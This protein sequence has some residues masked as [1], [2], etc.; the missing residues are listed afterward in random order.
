LAQAAENLIVRSLGRGDALAE[1]AHARCRQLQHT[2]TPIV[3][4]YLA[5]NQPVRLQLVERRD[6]VPRIDP[7]HVRQRLL[8][9]RALRVQLSQHVQVPRPDSERS[10]VLDEPAIDRFGYS[11]QEK[12]G[13]RLESRASLTGG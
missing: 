13:S 12:A 7:D 5:A 6:Q 10:K 1:H 3:R 9:Q 8:R 2:P 11:D 4:I